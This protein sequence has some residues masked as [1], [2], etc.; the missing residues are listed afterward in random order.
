VICEVMNDDGSMARLDDLVAFAQHHNLKLGTI[1]DLI[2]FRHQHDRLIERVSET[3][4]ETS[5]TGD[6]KAIAYRNRVDQSELLALVKGRPSAFSP[7]LVRM[8]VPDPLA[9]MFGACGPREGLL[10]AAMHAINSAGEGVIVVVSPNPRTVLTSSIR[11]SADPAP[12]SANVLREYGIGAQVLA[13]LGV[14]QLILLTN[15]HLE[16]IG[17]GGYGLQLIEE[18]RL[19][20]VGTPQHPHA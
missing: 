9:D 13:D 20:G 10:G 12:D 14:K 6:W 4:F 18:R 17:L 15:S 19:Y 2:Q 1:R 3:A 7:T 11:Q 8:H 5:T 16:P